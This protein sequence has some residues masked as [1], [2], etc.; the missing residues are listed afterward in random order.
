M[1]F[2]LNSKKNIYQWT[3]LNYEERQEEVI[4]LNYVQYKVKIKIKD[5]VFHN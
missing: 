2:L 3:N 1:L 5:H 4:N